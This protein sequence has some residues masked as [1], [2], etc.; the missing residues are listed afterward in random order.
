MAVAD[1]LSPEEWERIGERHADDMLLLADAI[2]NQLVVD[3]L[4]RRVA[5]LTWRDRKELAAMI[6]DQLLCERFGEAV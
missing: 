3:G 2:V 6:G 4:G 5:S 1:W